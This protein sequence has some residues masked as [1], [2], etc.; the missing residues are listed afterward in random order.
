VIVNRYALAAFGGLDG[1]LDGNKPQ[2]FFS[3][4]YP[5]STA[6]FLAE[7]S[8]AIT[9][10]A[11]ALA[12]YRTVYMMRPIPE[13]GVDVPKTLSRRMTFGM[14]D[15]IYVSM[16]SYLRRNGWVF[17]AQDAARDQCGVKILDPLP[18]LCQNG[19]CYGSKSGRPLYYDDNHLSEFGNKQLIPLFR[20]VI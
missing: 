18:Y 9:K 13:M 16:N 11:C 20:E 5:E 4:V 2:V 15:D 10:S 3:A 8:Q 12:R 17:A 6:K 1:R 14:K 19:L 7:F